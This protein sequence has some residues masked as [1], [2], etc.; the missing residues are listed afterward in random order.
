MCQDNY[1]VISALSLIV[2]QRLL[3]KLCPHC[4]GAGCERC[5]RT[6]YLGRAPVA[7]FVALDEALRTRLREAGPEVIAPQPTLAEAALELVA[8]KESNQAE[9]HRLFGR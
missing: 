6:G 4:A 2:N 8:E 5:L 3:R 9:F 7:E 1:A